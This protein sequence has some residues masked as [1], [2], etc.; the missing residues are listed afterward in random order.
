MSPRS[1]PTDVGIGAA[2][3][4]RRRRALRGRVVSR[5]AGRR[6]RDRPHACGA[7]RPIADLPQSADAR[8]GRASAGS[9]PGAADG[10][11][12]M[13]GVGCRAARN[14]R[15]VRLP[16]ARPAAATASPKACTVGAA[17]TLTAEEIIARHQAVGGAPGRRDAAA[18]IAE[19]HVDA[20]VRGAGLRRAG[21][22]SR[23]R[24]RSSRQR[25]RASTCGRRD[26]RVNGVAFSPRDG[27]PRLPILE[28]ERV[29]PL[30][31]A[32]TLTSVY[33]YTLAGRDTVDGT[34]CYVIGVRARRARRLALLAGAR[35]STI[36]TFA[37]VRVSAA[38]TGL[39]GPIVASEQTD[40]LH[41]RRA[42]PLAAGALRQS[43]RPTKAPASARP[44]TACCV[45]RAA[46]SQRRRLRRAARAAYASTDV[47]LRDTPRGLPLFEARSRAA[48]A[49]LAR[50]R[51][52]GGALAASPAAGD[53]ASARFAARR[54]RRSE[55][56]HAAAVR[57]SQLRRLQ[58][59]RAPARSS[60][61]SSAAATG[62]WRS[63]RR[64]SR[65]TRWQLAGRAFGIATSYND[66]AFVEGREIYTRDIRQ[67]PAQAAV[68]VLRPLGAAGRAA[69]SSTT[70]TTTGSARGDDRPTPA[71]VVPATRTR[72]ALR[73]GLDLQR[74][75]WQASV[76]ASHTRRIGWRRV[77]RARHREYARAH[78]DVRARRR[79][80]AAR[81]A[82]LSP[83]RDDAG[84]RRRWW[85]AAISIDSAGFAFGTFDNRLHGY[86]SALIRYDRGA[87][88]RTASSWSAGKADSARRLRRHRRRPRSGIRPRPAQ[89]HRLRRRAR[90]ARRR[91][92]RCVAV[93]WGYGVQGVN[94]NGRTRHPG[95]C[96]SPAYKV[97]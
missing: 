9:C 54:D 93:E 78:A 96:G 19:R 3:H 89:L 38:Q 76:W 14:R 57:R 10:D 81:S 18:T 25:Q 91:S 68:W 46:R 85:P 37:M 80:R 88:L 35:G 12:D 67:R 33:R 49:T 55:H 8:S 73:A 22:R 77:G 40:R 62:S 43:G 16:R 42:G 39:R 69:R 56:Q 20:H 13:P 7:D 41:A 6:H 23:R 24:R 44:S 51:Q 36:D 15:R 79:Q 52:T 5:R 84:R 82:A 28:P 48:A 63:R 53:R 87:V 95:A 70:G 47:M 94:T 30:P 75:G 74:A 26:I 59:V 64:R 90:G 2:A 32:I 97:F 61:A 86:P 72:T 21:Q 60:A 92:A 17:R 45:D 34:P 31:L 1:A 58:S 71:F 65:G 50:A 4:R 29:P 83:R 66:R 27:V 11:R